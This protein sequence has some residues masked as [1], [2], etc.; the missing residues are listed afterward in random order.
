MV[1]LKLLIFLLPVLRTASWEEIKEDILTFRPLPKQ[2]LPG[3]QEQYPC[4]CRLPA[5]DETK[6]INTKALVQQYELDLNTSRTLQKD[7]RKLMLN[8]TDEYQLKRLD[9]T[10]KY[11]L[12]MVKHQEHSLKSNGNVKWNNCIFF[13][14]KEIRWSIRFYHDHERE[15]LKTASSKDAETK[16]NVEQLEKQIAQWR[17][18]YR[19]LK[20]RCIDENSGNKKARECLVRYMQNDNFDQVIQRLLVLKQGAMTEQEAYFESTL[21]DLEEC[22][23]SLLSRYLDSIRAIMQVLSKCYNM[24]T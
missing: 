20:N 10:M 23:R 19:Y 4:P 14:R 5:V 15:C 22:L 13:H 24:E 6:P 18:G 21:V 3:N 16:E 7:D 2:G 11:R 12:Q 9:V 1:V 8:W 17:K